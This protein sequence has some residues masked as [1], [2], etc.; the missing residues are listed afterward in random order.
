[1]GRIRENQQIK[2]NR[3]TSSNKRAL[4]IHL[5]SK[6]KGK[7]QHALCGAV[8][9]HSDREKARSFAAVMT[10]GAL[11]LMPETNRTLPRLLKECKI[12]LQE[13]TL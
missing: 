1:M 2:M 12:E 5:I 10:P 9:P 4:I 8:L 7:R 11:C 3:E 13:A 6:L